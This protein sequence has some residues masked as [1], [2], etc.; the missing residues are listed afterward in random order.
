M[1]IVNEVTV[2]D[3]TELKLKGFDIKQIDK[4]MENVL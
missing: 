3:F 4:I 1:I 2:D